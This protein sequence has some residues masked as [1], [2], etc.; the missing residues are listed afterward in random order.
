MV[1]SVESRE[2]CGRHF[3]KPISELR[4]RAVF[5]RPVKRVIRGLDPWAVVAGTLVLIALVVG[6]VDAWFV[7]TADILRLTGIVVLGAGGLLCAV[8][9]S[10]V[11]AV[12]AALLVAAE[13]REPAPVGTWVVAGA[14][15]LM[16]ALQRQRLDAIAAG[17]LF[18][19]AGALADLPWH[20]EGSFDGGAFGLTMLALAMVGVGQWVQAQRRYVTA[21]IGRRREE[22]ERRREEIARNVAEERL[23]IAREL[24]DSVAH[25]IAVVSVQT[26][27]ARAS[28]NTSLPATDRALQAVQLAARSVLE[29]LQQV[30]GV[31]RDE[32]AGN[33]LPDTVGPEQI[34]DLCA[35]YRQLGL[36]VHV[37]GLPAFSLLPHAARVALHRV[38]Q[39]ALTNAYRYGDGR[40]ELVF[41]S[42]HDNLVEVRVH[43]EVRQRSG[44]AAKTGGH[45]LVGMQ[46]RVRALGGRLQAGVDGQVFTVTARVP[47]A[48]ETKGDV[49]G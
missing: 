39:E 48:A 17:L 2:G 42:I 43:N 26:N 12:V 13:V 29:E 8:R 31:L 9:R 40:A 23:R 4:R 32:R 22:A 25:H 41:E 19:A 44:T 36:E 34:S 28:L 30:L 11:T 18:A 45:G 37:A 10:L 14:L 49:D 46:E 33:G 27:L 38:L 15:L 24:H 20:D 16:F 47:V 5:S 35:S 21:E 3:M 7:A 6:A 1:M